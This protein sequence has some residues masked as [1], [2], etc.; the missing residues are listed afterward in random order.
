MKR[1]QRFCVCG[2]PDTAHARETRDSLGECTALL[3]GDVFCDCEAYIH[4]GD[5]EMDT[6]AGSG[7]A[8]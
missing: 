3:D 5:A 6:S 7:D 4:E 2:H 8:E 1:E